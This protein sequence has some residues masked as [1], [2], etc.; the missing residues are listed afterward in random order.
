[1]EQ[2]EKKHREII[3]EIEEGLIITC[4]NGITAFEAIEYAKNNNIKIIITD[5]HQIEKVGDIDKLPKADAILNPHRQ[6]CEYPFKELCG[7][8][9]GKIRLED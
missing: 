3:D 4:D 5:H 9:V 2:L 8:A 1:M 7:A 6:D